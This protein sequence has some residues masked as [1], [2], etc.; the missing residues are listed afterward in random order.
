MRFVKDEAAVRLER[1]WRAGCSVAE[2]LGAG[3]LD[4]LQRDVDFVLVRERREGPGLSRFQTCRNGSSFQIGVYR[5]SPLV[6]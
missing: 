3:R 6:T 1:R 4:L 5:G 2:V